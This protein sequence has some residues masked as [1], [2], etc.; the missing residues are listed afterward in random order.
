MLIL[1]QP[2]MILHFGSVTNQTPCKHTILF[3]SYW[4]VTLTF[5][6]TATSASIELPI[7]TKPTLD[8]YRANISGPFIRGGAEGCITLGESGVK[9]AP[10]ILEPKGHP[11]R[12]SVSCSII[13][14]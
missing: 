4:K 14:N 12:N 9:E 7:G 2:C 5:F 10:E 6:P 13:H 1:I 8:L 11:I 3:V